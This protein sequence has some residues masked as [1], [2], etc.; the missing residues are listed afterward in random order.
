MTVP[1]RIG[2]ASV[3]A[4]MS[5]KPLHTPAGQAKTDLEIAAETAV[6]SLISLMGPRLTRLTAI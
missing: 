1:F 2:V 4:L 5:G 3:V 6:Q